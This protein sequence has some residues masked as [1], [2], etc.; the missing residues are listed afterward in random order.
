MARTVG[1][2]SVFFAVLA[3]VGLALVYP[4]PA[5]LRGAPWFVVAVAGFWA[6]LLAIESLS[7]PTYPPVP[8]DGLHGDV[9]F[10]PPPPPRARQG[11]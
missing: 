3:L 10:A 7:A 4:T 6:L 9:P 2:S 8:K 5:D 1:R 11:D